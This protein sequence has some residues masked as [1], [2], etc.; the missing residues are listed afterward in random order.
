MMC[1]QYMQQIRLLEM[2]EREF[3]HALVAMMD[4][5]KPDNAKSAREALRLAV[6]NR[7]ACRVALLFH[8]RDHG[9]PTLSVSA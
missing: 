8:E 7:N 2:A 4:A 1:S 5:I 3:H 6:K 9:C